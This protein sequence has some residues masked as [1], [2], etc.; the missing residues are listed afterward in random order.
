MKTRIVVAAVGIPLLVAVIF[1]APDIVF[2]CVVGAIA[3]CAAYEFLRCTEPDISMPLRIVS[4]I[5]AALYPIGAVYAK[6]D[7]ISHAAIYILMLFV[8]IELILSFRKKL[9]LAVE[10]V[11]SVMFAAGIIPMMLTSLVRL[12]AIEEAGAVYILLPFVITMT[13]DSGAYFVGVFL[14]RHKL[15][16]RVSPN[17]T[18]EGATGGFV[19]GTLCCL[20]YGFILKVAGYEVNLL[21]MACYGFL[22]S[23]V[24]QLGDLS[25]SAIKRLAGV[26]D[27]GNIIPGHGGALDR[28]DSIVF[29]AP[30]VE[31]LM[32]WVPAFWKG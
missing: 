28:F 14:G 6:S 26:K 13:C 12:G 2:A 9:T 7:V 20:L 22:G 1:F 29:V 4:M 3:A 31:V 16:P 25:F 17:K 19:F 32:L 30:L 24:C 8:F 11:M 18:I 27:Y 23:F 5:C 21:L 10:S 15:A